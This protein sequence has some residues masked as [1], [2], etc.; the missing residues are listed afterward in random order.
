MTKYLGIILIALALVIAIF[1]Q[2]TDCQSQGKAITLANGNQIPMKC[3]WTGEAELGLGIPIL[4]VGT[5]LTFFRRQETLR[6]LS[7]IGIILGVM[8]VLM[9][10]LLIG[11]CA[12]PTMICHSTMKPVL[13]ISGSLVTVLS[14][15]G[16]ALT[17]RIKEHNVEYA[18][19]RI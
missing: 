7:L 14:G 8:S 4:A 16:I 17:Y 18:K 5:M 19:S 9:P 6:T 12:S 11:V 15:A 10:V 1:P 13:I 3:H 2:F